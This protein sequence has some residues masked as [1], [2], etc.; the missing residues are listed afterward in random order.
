MFVPAPPP[1]ST[2]HTADITKVAWNTQ[3]VHILASAAQNGSTIVW[4]L[5]QKKAWY[6]RKVFLYSAIFFFNFHLGVLLGPFFSSFPL[7]P[8][9]FH[10]IVSIDYH[11]QFKNSINWNPIHI[12]ITNVFWQSPC[13]W[14]S[15]ILSFLFLFLFFISTSNS[16]IFPYFYLFLTFVSITYVFFSYFLVFFFSYFLFKFFRCELRDPTGGCVSDV[17]WNP[18]QGMESVEHLYS[19]NDKVRF[20]IMMFSKYLMLFSSFLFLSSCIDILSIFLYFDHILTM[21]LY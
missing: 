16:I 13:W 10:Q 20:T 9:F 3:V 4:D 2:K 11:N 5:R 18:D 7:F 15:F 19:I 12:Y 14:N 6:A 8:P 21:K 17:A 1:N